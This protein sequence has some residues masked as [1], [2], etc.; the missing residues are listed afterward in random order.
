MDDKVALCKNDL[1]TLACPEIAESISQRPAAAFS[2]VDIST[3]PEVCTSPQQVEASVA[4]LLEG[5]HME[6]LL[7]VLVNDGTSEF[8]LRALIDT[9]AK[10]ALLI[11]NGILHN[12]TVASNPLNLVTANG[13][14]M[15]GGQFG[16]HVTLKIPIALP[17]KK[18]LLPQALTLKNQW[19]YEADIRGVD[20]IM[21]YPF[22]VAMRLLPIPSQHIL[23]LDTDFIVEQQKILSHDCEE[24]QPW[25]TT[26]TP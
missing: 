8:T 7:Q 14:P 2:M 23:M 16:A 3:L 22:V 21:G 10:V 24:H 19:A 25:P 6:L 26:H 15:N 4:Q 13:A 18:K 5:K 11:N 12:T 17:C 20:M 1:S 9:G